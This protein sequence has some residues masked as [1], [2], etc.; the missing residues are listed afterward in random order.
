MKAIKLINNENII[1]ML[2]KEHFA[3]ALLCNGVELSMMGL[4]SAMVFYHLSRTKTLKTDRRLSVIITISLLIVCIA[5]LLIS[6]KNYNYRIKYL[7]DNCEKNCTSK[8]ISFVNNIKRDNNILTIVLILI[9]L[10]IAYLVFN[11]V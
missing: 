4:T 3:E 8:E 9:Q 1:Y 7:L 6:L 10:L 5:Y 2:E 11:T